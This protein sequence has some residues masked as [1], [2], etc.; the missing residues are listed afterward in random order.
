MPKSERRSKNEL[1]STRLFP[2]GEGADKYEV[3]GIA[4]LCDWVVFSDRSSPYTA[5]KGAEVCSNPETIFLSFRNPFAA[6]L[7]FHINVL[8]R[9]KKPFVL[10]SGSSDV[11]IP[12]QIDLRWRT[13][14]TEEHKMIT[15]ILDHPLL[16]HWFAENLDSKAHRK[17]AA[18]PL[19]MLSNEPTVWSESARRTDNTS[20]SS[21]PNMVLCAHRVRQGPQWEPRRTVSHLAKE[22][23]NEFC[24]VVDTELSEAEYRDQLEK[25]RFVLCVEGGGLDPSPKVWHAILAGCIPIICRSALSNVYE[26]NL[27][28]LVIDGWNAE[29]LSMPILKREEIRLSPHFSDTKKRKL[30]LEKLKLNFWWG[31]IQKKVEGNTY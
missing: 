12:N 1:H 7:F 2:I 5:L 8:P 18:L 14:S 17:M 24:S 20:F 27:P 11:T 13:F 23:W 3:T 10:I 19:G 6:L 28:T 16:V 31:I 22:Y 26:D 29:S 30:V 21:R 25:H 15:D 9:L 4:S